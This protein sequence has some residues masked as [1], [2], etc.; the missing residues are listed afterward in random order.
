MLGKGYLARWRLRRGA[1]AGIDHGL[2]VAWESGALL[3]A[4]GSSIRISGGNG[5]GVEERRFYELQPLEDVWGDLA[6]V[7]GRAVACW[8]VFGTGDFDHPPV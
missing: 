8:D 6:L 7:A 4:E 5:D 1:V 2:V 3:G